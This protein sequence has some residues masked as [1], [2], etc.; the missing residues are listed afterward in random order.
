LGHSGSNNNG[1][2]NGK[3]ETPIGEN[4]KPENHVGSGNMSLQAVRVVV[5]P[6]GQPSSLCC[7]SHDI[8]TI[9]T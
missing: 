9:T 2:K 1:V 6:V 5:C 7:V 4:M 3:H 8:N